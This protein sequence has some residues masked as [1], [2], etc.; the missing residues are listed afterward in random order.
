M[1]KYIRL[2]EEYTDLEERTSEVNYSWQDVRNTIQSKLPFT[3]IDFKTSDAR[4][5]C[6]KSELFD[7]KYIKQSYTLKTEDGNT[8]RYPSVFIIGEDNKV[9]DRVLDLQ[10]RFDILRIVIGEY[11]KDIPSLYAEGDEVQIGGNLYPSLE[12][13]DMAGEDYYT[14]GSNFFKFID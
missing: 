14:N 11:G 12:I 2:Y 8:V 7:E 1:R 10:K 6:I 5:E 3:I 4:D 13:N 9:Q